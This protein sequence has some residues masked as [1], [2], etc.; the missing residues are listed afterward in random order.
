M[1]TEVTC[2][3]RGRVVLEFKEFVRS[4]YGD[5]D[6]LLPSWVDNSEIELSLHSC[7]LMN[8]LHCDLFLSMFNLVSV[9]LI[10]GLSMFN[11]CSL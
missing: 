1:D 7:F 11:F 9:C 10:F 5:A 6:R 4:N 8:C 2:E 3:T